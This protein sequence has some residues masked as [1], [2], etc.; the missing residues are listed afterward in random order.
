MPPGRVPQKADK[1]A[2]DEMSITKRVMS[3][4][5]SVR[6]GAS[7]ESNCNL[8]AFIGPSQARGRASI[9]GDFQEARAAQERE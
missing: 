9:G 3:R 6:G 4:F 1:L 5:G 8:A 7:R 2:H